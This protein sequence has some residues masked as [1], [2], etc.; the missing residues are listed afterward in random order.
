MR[1]GITEILRRSPD[2]HVVGEAGDAREAMRLVDELDPDLVVLDIVLRGGM[3]GLELLKHFK[4]S[5]PEL[6]VLVLSMRDERLF[7]ERALAAGARGYLTKWESPDRIEEAIEL[8]MAGGIQ[9]S[10][11]LQAAMVRLEHGGGGAPASSVALLSDR[12]LEVFELI[13]QG[14]TTRAIA[15]QLHISV[16]TVETHRVHIKAKLRLD[17]AVELVR[18]AVQHLNGSASE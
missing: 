8:I 6:L 12:E 2:N 1:A 17:N 16:K 9:A 3:N 13:G 5:R 7:G 11:E 10:Q 4:Q 18:A 15:Q 14:Q